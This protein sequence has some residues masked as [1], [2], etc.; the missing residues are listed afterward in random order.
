MSTSPRSTITIDLAAVRHNVKFLRE[1]LQPSTRFLAA[2][3]ADA[4][5]HGAL[6][7]SQAV[8]QA[9]ADGVAVA[10]AEEA[11]A[12]RDAGFDSMILVMGPLYSIDQ[13]A[14]MARRRVEFAVVSDEM[15]EIVLAMG[16]SG[17][18]ARLH[19]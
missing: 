8:M 6:A 1:K 11:A 13:C 4:Y 16:R 15:A 18:K 5:G 17:L 12:L 19:F 3:K 7:V 9:G 14:E 10:T 2:V